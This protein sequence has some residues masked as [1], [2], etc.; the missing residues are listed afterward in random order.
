MHNALVSFVSPVYK[1]RD[2]LIK[3]V[4]EIKTVCAE[5]GV[6]YE[7]ILVDD[8]CPQGSWETIEELA[9][10]NDRVTGVK[11]SRNFGQHS[12]IEAGLGQTK[13]DWIVVLDCDL[14]D[15]PSNVKAMWHVAQEGNVDIVLAKRETRTDALHRR[16]FS[17]LFYKTLSSLT[18]TRISADIANFGLYRRRVVDVFNSWHEEQKYFPVMIQWMGFD[19][20]TVTVKHSERFSGK[21][22]YNLRN[23]LALGARVILSFSDRPL[24]LMSAIGS[25]IAAGAF[26]VTLIVLIRALFGDVIVQGWTS[27]MLSIWFLGG[28]NIAAAG[29]LGIYLGR[30]LRE[31]KG[32]PGF[33]IARTTRNAQEN[34]R[35]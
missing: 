23:L 32:R 25:T 9:A 14:Q 22:A 31:S 17:F 18:G 30:T 10:T 11:L 28:V 3:L 27:L 29:L 5:I 19:Q 13:G 12:A 2:C 34:P 26:F 1:C 4:E 16:A 7:V 15:Q 33:I 35:V 24:W 20:R 6:D 21:S 8:K